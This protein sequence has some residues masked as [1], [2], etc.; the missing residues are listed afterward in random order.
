MI[1]GY[2]ARERVCVGY[3]LVDLVVLAGKEYYSPSLLSC[4]HSG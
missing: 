4:S 3:I 2:G 1:G